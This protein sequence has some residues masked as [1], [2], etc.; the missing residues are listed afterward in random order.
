MDKLKNQR[1]LA[2]LEIILATAIIAILATVTVP[3]MAR[4]LDKISLNYEM[5]RL[6]ST[7]HFTRS[8]DK[9]TKYNVSIFTNVFDTGA[10]RVRL[11]IQKTN[12]LIKHEN[13]SLTDFIDKHFWAS[14]FQFSYPAALKIIAFDSQGKGLNA[15]NG[16]ADGTIT[17]TS[18]FGDKAYITVNSVGRIRGSYEKPK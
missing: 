15:N 18:R 9:L 5:K 10:G 1:G 11:H 13:N 2:A 8:V 14:G 3:K 17:L 7:L 12:Y 6:Y 16:A 4:V